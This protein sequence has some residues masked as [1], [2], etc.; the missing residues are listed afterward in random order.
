MNKHKHQI[1]Y[2]KYLIQIHERAK[3]H[4]IIINHQKT[5]TS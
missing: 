5:K 4:G 1:R 2:N 3:N